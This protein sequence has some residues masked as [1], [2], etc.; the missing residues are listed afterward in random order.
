MVGAGSAGCVLAARIADRYQV[1]LI[2]AGRLVAAGR[3]DRAVDEAVAHPETWALPVR[4]AANVTGRAR[5]GRAVGGSSVVNGGYWAV[6]ASADLDAWHARG[7]DAWAPER[8]RALMDELGD[9]LDAH[10]SPLSH[11]VTRAFTEAADGLVVPLLTTIVD[12]SP[13]TVAG[14]FLDDRVQV[15]SDCRVLRVLI[16]GGRAVGVEVADAEGELTV[17]DAD[18]VVLC[19]G[20]FGTARLLLASGIGPADE[21]SALGITPVLDAPGVGTGFSDHPTVWVE[22]MPR[23]DAPVPA[24]RPED[25]HGAFPLALRLGADGGAGDDIE[26]LVCTQPPS[27]EPGARTLGL[28]VGLQRPGARGTVRAAS[29]HPLAAPAIEYHYLEDPRDRAAL[30]LGVRRAAGILASDAFAGLVA[31]LVDLDATTL[32]DD[33]ALDAWIT[34][35]LGSAAHTCGTAPLGPGGDP[36][37]VVDAAG[38]VRGVAGLRIADA[39]VLPHVPS[40]GPVAAVMAVGAIVADQM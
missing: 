4:L 30:R 6:P 23:P 16:E 26:I 20:G 28:I 38:R 2:E 40:C 24:S 15:R 7:G 36:L 19:A 10:P 11:P 32:A 29:A 27:P 31:G 34:R 18:E 37:A 21:L 5:P 13:R 1:V 14:A 35:H 3:A 39:S 17:I 12:G 22:W 25:E 8:L 9:R 33:A